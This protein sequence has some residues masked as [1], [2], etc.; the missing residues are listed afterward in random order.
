MSTLFGV[1]DKCK[2]HLV[3]DS[4]ESSGVVGLSVTL[5]A[6]VLDTDELRDLS[7]STK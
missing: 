2:T 5:S 3:K 6:I 7:V 1:A 4:L